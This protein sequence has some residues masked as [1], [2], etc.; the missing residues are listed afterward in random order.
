M[1]YDTRISERG[2]TM[3]SDSAWGIEPPKDADGKAIPLDTDVLYS[4]SGKVFNVECFCYS[5]I[6]KEWLA[7]GR[8]RGS[9]D[10]RSG[11]GEASH[12]F[13][14]THDSW[15]KLVDCK[16]DRETCRSVSGDQNR[17]ECSECRC[18][19]ELVTEVCNE[20]GEPFHVPLMPSFCPNC[21]AEVVD[22]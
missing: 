4:E 5:L 3:S 2:A 15:D 12:Y 11:C 7:Y 16:T 19:A 22:E 13:L 1:S 20:Y 10:E 18:R 8:H 17:F 21:G 14:T 6:Y 9:E